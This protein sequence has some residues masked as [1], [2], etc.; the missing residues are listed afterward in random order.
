MEK[1]R[2]WS[3][4]EA[5]ARRSKSGIYFNVAALTERNA[6]VPENVKNRHV[7]GVSLMHRCTRV[8]ISTTKTDSSNLTHAPCQCD[9][10]QSMCSSQSWLSSSCDIRRATLAERP[11]SLVLSSCWRNMDSS[12]LWLRLPAPQQI[13]VAIVVCSHP[14]DELC[15]DHLLVAPH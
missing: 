14:S 5:R 12:I 13:D 15:A 2:K 4:V 9:S 11:G 8:K 3:S 1:Y 6:I 10:H 7:V